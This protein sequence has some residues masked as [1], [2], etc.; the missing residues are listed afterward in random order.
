MRQESVESADDGFRPARL[1]CSVA[2]ARGR[3][4]GV[5]RVLGP[6]SLQATL[7]VRDPNWE[8]AAGE[9][10]TLAVGASACLRM[11]GRIS[12]CEQEEPG[13]LLVCVQLEG[14]AP[15][16]AAFRALLASVRPNILVVD[17]DTAH[18]AAVRAALEPRYR[19][20]GCASGAE[21]L[22]LMEGE[23][24]A[25]LLADQRLPDGSGT[26]F[27]R[28]MTRRH[29]RG[30]AARMIASAYTKAE[31]VQDLINLG[32]IFHYLRKPV[33][34]SELIQAVNRGARIHALAMENE[35]LARELR[36]ANHRLR[37][38]NASLRR[39]LT[40]AEQAQAAMVGQ[41]PGFLRALRDLDQMGA[42]DTAVHIAGETGTGKELVAR[43]IHL[44]SRRARGP[45]I[46]QSCAALPET[47]IQS[48]FFGHSRGA[49]T[50]A[51][52]DRPGIF[53]TAHGGTLFL[54]EV[55]ELPLPAQAALLR[56]LQEGEI[57]PVGSSRPVRVDVRV[58][59]ATH[60][61]LRVEVA[62]GRFRE[63][64]YFRLVVVP[65]EVPPL[66]ERRMDV[67]LLANHFLRVLS[68]RMGKAVPGFT[69]EA[70][71]A[72]TEYDWPG[73]VR[74][75]R[76]EVE[77]AMVLSPAHRPLAVEVLSDQVRALL[78]DA[79][80][81]PFADLPNYD[82]AVRALERDLVQRALARSGGVVSRAADALG[83]ERTRLTKMRRRLG[84]P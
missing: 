73:N 4:E 45:F 40:S 29:P 75:L 52:R 62:A 31:D 2:S 15:A 46:A 11:S 36:H 25:V 64:L 68:E 55:A 16:L 50:G 22:A 57:F 24:V 76:N 82:D 1:A 8:P 65:L 28:E 48:A 17:P 37:H 78:R 49:F 72:L 34:A 41:S 80:P 12:W 70:L 26:A 32:R 83:M 60:R 14:Q 53:Q 33:V 5:T 61:K 77:R 9:E 27:L 38:E 3:G 18:T 42:C 35:R 44:R 66:R 71:R 74:E 84:L 10:V 81:A 23:E 6:G 43:A 21:A 63:D 19:V 79:P 58:I 54:D 7:R 13:G 51:D 56:V 20:L 39:R 59:S 69:E 47:L 30:H 67:P